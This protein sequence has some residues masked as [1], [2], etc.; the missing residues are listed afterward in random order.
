[1][2]ED[3]A[4]TAAPCADQQPH[5]IA[6][7]GCDSMPETA[8]RILVA[9]FDLFAERGFEAVSVREICA[10]AG[11][12]KPVVYYHFESRDGVVLAVVEAL[13]RGWHA[14]CDAALD[15][16]EPSRAALSGFVR[17]L[18]EL[19]EGD[20]PVARILSRFPSLPPALM[21]KAADP[22]RFESRL[23]DWL[24]RGRAAGA[25]RTDL[26]SQ[27]VTWLL[28]GAFN[29]LAMLRSVFPPTESAANVAERLV[30][31]ALGPE[32]P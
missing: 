30:Q 14:H 7:I 11:V 4:A 19:A 20:G 26:D 13:E 31:A 32:A 5:P 8:V 28:L 9:A 6:T 25:F 10:A 24:E 22:T 17:G 2:S 29:R 15:V 16:H 1:M 21:R 23:G 12:S 27:A 3:S 18:L